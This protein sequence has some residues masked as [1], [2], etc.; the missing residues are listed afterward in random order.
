MTGKHLQAMLAERFQI[1]QMYMEDN[2]SGTEDNMGKGDIAYPAVSNSED[3]PKV[4]PVERLLSD[5]RAI[6]KL[7]A[8]TEPPRVRL[9][10]REVL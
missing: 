3:P 8:T 5:V 10:A 9:R 4:L 7:T 6:E 1:S 2:T